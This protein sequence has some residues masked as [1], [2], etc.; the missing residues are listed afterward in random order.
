MRAYTRQ[1]GSPL[2]PPPPPFSLLVEK[3]RA[4]AHLLGQEANRGCDSGRGHG[5][6][7][8]L[9][10]VASRLMTVKSRRGGGVKG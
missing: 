9:T 3:G 10:T 8:A 5:T 7:L 2:P 1:R 4:H 6:H